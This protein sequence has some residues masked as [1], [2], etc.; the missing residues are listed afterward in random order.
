MTEDRLSDSSFAGKTVVITGGSRGLG[1]AMVE[2]FTSLGA[3]VYFTFH[4]RA[5][6]A[7]SLG[8]ATGAIAIQCSQTDPEAIEAAVNRILEE[9]GR[10][11]VLVNNA[12]I[13][14]DQFLAMMPPASWDKVLDT[15][16]NGTFRWCRALTRPMLVARNGVIINI[17]SVSG[18][19]GIA[20][21]TNYAASKGAMLAFSRALAAELGPKGI[22]VNSVVPGFIETDMTAKIPRSIRQKN[23]ERILVRRFGRPDEVAA[24]VTFLASDQASYILDG[25]LTATGS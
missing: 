23:L 8:S 6:D 19:V 13:T 20:G 17:A 22:R 10:V 21:Q 1:R 4:R 24:V 11:D 2:R 12:G 14:E 16:L 3:R 7:E 9:S 5:E 15:N 18:L 25:G